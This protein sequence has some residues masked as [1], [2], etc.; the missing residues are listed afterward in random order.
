MIFVYRAVSNCRQYLL[1]DDAPVIQTTLPSKHLPLGIFACARRVWGDGRRHK[2]AAMGRTEASHF[3]GWVDPSQRRTKVAPTAT[4][5][6]S[7]FRECQQKQ[8]SEQ[9]TAPCRSPRS[10]TAGLGPPRG[11]PR[12][13]PATC[14][15]SVR[16]G[17]ARPGK[18]AVCD[19]KA[20]Q[21]FP[22]LSTISMSWRRCYDTWGPQGSAA[23]SGHRVANHSI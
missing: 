15:Y 8:A 19:V 23:E 20:A 11:H 17:P 1:P 13:A 2:E 14:P 3:F 10:G 7:P 21:I 18:V 4:T 12:P 22:A 5:H 9:W 16:R 6:C